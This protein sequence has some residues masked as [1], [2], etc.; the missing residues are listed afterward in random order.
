M[1]IRNRKPD[2]SREDFEE[3]VCELADRQRKERK[4]RELEG[5]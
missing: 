3:Y 4:E 1:N 2:E 5:R